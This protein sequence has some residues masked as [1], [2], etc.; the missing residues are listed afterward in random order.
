MNTTN[1]TSK[2]VGRTLLVCLLAMG[3]FSVMASLGLSYLIFREP[4]PIQQWTG[5]REVNGHLVQITQWSPENYA[6]LDWERP[7]SEEL[8][9]VVRAINPS[10]DSAFT[11]GSVRRQEYKWGNEFITI[12]GNDRKTSCFKPRKEAATQHEFLVL[13]KRV[14][15]TFTQ[16]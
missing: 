9:R 12:S 13:V 16:H 8:E 11:A 14:P 2:I 1:K 15:S 7:N 4:S 10:P 6:G 5:E 3:A